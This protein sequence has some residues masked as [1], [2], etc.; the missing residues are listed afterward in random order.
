[1]NTS[2]IFGMFPMEA[3]HCL[4]VFHLSAGYLERLRLSHAQWWYISSLWRQSIDPDVHPTRSINGRKLLPVYNDGAPGLS[5]MVSKG[6]IDEH[7]PMR[8]PDCSQRLHLQ[9][10]SI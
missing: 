7:Y 10:G 8:Q 3:G 2:Q 5:I 6:R 4:P 1:M 9:G